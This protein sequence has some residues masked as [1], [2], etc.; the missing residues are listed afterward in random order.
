M[1][2]NNKN[3][4]RKLGLISVT[5]L[6][7]GSA[8][9]AGIFTTIGDVAAHAGSSLFL[10]L[11]LAICSLFQI[12]S[13]LCYAQLSSAY[14]ED[15]G[16]Y[17]YFKK[18]NLKCFA[19]LSGWI[20]LFATDVPT[21]SM[22]GLALVNYL[23]ILF[24]LNNLLLKFIAVGVIIFISI[25]HIRSVEGGDKLQT[26]LTAFK[27][28]PFI[29]IILIGVF[30]IKPELIFDSSQNTNSDF[31]N[32]GP[33]GAAFP[34]FAAISVAF[35]AFDGLYS[36]CYVSGEIKNPKRNLPGGLILASI[37][38]LVLYVSLTCVTCGILSIDEITS[39]SAPIS[40]LASKFPLIGPSAKYIVAVVACIV[41]TGAL[42]SCMMYQPRIEYAMARDGYF[43]E[44]F[45]RVSEKYTTPSFAIAF[46]CIVS[47][48]LMFVS[49]L[50]SI[51]NYYTI[52]ILFK[53]L[54]AFVCMLLLKNKKDYK[55][56][57]KA[58]FGDALP[59]FCIIFICV[60]MVS[61]VIQVGQ[62][63]TIL[64][65]VVTLSGVPVYFLWDYWKNKK[66]SKT[67]N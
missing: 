30:F 62:V 63:G 25:M 58:P 26:F 4:K 61:T 35:F 22:M 65:I 67:T 31:G 23:S 40:L 12:P 46:H 9:G 49:D 59:I 5:S 10:I 27:I 29:L 6:A 57:Y 50:S 17:V 18:A 28:I 32:L 13:S 56:T 15:G 2:Q 52:V 55:P 44:I 45:G 36:P 20:S 33:L 47:I 43:F 37:I 60:C 21:I 39:S 38:I 24:P 3:L 54:G 66:P 7:V 11:A 14:P 48:A 64:A 51:L 34:M 1:N 42:S 16:H 8:V 41:I 19:F 53:H